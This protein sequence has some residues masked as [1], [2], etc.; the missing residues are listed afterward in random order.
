MSRMQATVI[1]DEKSDDILRGVLCV[2]AERVAVMNIS[3][4]TRVL[5]IILRNGVE[6]VRTG[7]T[8]DSRCPQSKTVPVIRPTAKSESK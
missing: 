1:G 4:G 5:R 7:R 2:A 6:R 3:K 8:T